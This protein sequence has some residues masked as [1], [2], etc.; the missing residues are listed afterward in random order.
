MKPTPLLLAAM[1]ALRVDNIGDTCPAWIAS[2]DRKC[3]KPRA[4]GYLCARHDKVARRTW[5]TRAAAEATRYNCCFTFD[6]QRDEWY[7]MIAHLQ[8]CLPALPHLQGWHWTYFQGK[9]AGHNQRTAMA[10]ALL[11]QMVFD[12]YLD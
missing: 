5:E 2:A 11:C 3:G 4:V 1:V 9:L 12:V 10:L 7:V 8:E 6:R